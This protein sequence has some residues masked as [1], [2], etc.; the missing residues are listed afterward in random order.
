MQK[1]FEIENLSCSYDRDFV[2]GQSKVVLEIRHLVLPR[3]KKIFIV[4]ES[5][6]GKSTILE[7]LGLMNNTIVPNPATRFVF[8]DNNGREVD[9]MALWAT[10]SDKELSAFRLRHFNFIFQST[11]LMRNFSAYE[12]IAITRML[13]G[14]SRQESFSKAAEILSDLGLG[15]LDTERR[16]QELSGG[17]QQRLAFARAVLPDFTVLFGDEPTGNLDPENAMRAMELLSGKLARLEGSSAVIVTHDMHLAGTFADIV[18]KVRKEVR[19][20][21]DVHG[22]VDLYGL[23]DDTSVFVP[24]VGR[25]SWSNG[26]ETCPAEEFESFLRQKM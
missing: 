18:I 4:G 22:E 15:S 5:G 16:A 12:N 23:I 24:D 25:K 26:R 2:P 20:E 10:N 21:K 14:Y 8:Y 6:I 3:G 1:L 11:N 17:Q 19:A 9:L 7:V 13:Q